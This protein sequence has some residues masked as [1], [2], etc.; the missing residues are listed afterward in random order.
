MS[1]ISASLATNFDQERQEIHVA[2]A[3]LNK[4]AG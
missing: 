1:V 2:F 4:K 3:H